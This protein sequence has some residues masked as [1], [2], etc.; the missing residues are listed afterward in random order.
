MYI[1]QRVFFHFDKRKPVLHRWGSKEYPKRRK[2]AFL[3][4]LHICTSLEVDP[5]L[6]GSQGTTTE[7]AFVSP[8]LCSST[9]TKRYTH[10]IQQVPN[11]DINNFVGRKLLD[12]IGMFCFP[13]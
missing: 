7:S 9:N 10:H 12:Y 3:R 4:T 5:T 11:L 1:H 13:S 8:V 6:E 2:K